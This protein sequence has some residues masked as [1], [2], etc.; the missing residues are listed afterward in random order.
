MSRPHYDREDEQYRESK[1]IKGHEQALI[2]CEFDANKPVG[3]KCQ[4]VGS[5]I[6]GTVNPFFPCRFPTTIVTLRVAYK[7]SMRRF[8][9]FPLYLKRTVAPVNQVTAAAERVT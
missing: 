5:T 9:A 3:F 6:P 4:D 7:I 2:T 1:G 8:A